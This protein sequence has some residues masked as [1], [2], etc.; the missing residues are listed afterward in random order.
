MKFGRVNFTVRVLCYHPGECFLNDLRHQSQVF[1]PTAS[2]SV[3]TMAEKSG[4]GTSLKVLQP[5]RLI[6][7]GELTKRPRPK[8][9]ELETGVADKKRKMGL[10]E[11]KMGLSNLTRAK[12]KSTMNLA[13][14]STTRGGRLN[15]TTTTT[16]P[17]LNRY[18]VSSVRPGIDRRATT[19]SALNS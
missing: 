11:P 5:S 3:S 1:R 19:A 15:T 4:A 7:P 16:R 14:K 17:A 2:E 9:I 6:T 10:P 8:S 13:D 12:S 18:T